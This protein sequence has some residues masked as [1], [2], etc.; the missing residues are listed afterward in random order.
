LNIRYQLAKGIGSIALSPFTFLRGSTVAE[1]VYK[2]GLEMLLESSSPYAHDATEQSSRPLPEFYRPAEAFLTRFERVAATVADV[3][4]RNL[5]DIGCAEGYMI[6]RVA[7]ECGVFALGLEMDRR[8]IRV[9]NATSELDG[10]HDYGIVPARVGPELLRRLPK[11]DVVVCFSVLHHVIRGGG[12]EAG[13]EFLEAIRTITGRRFVFDMDSPKETA[14]D[15]EWAD[16]LGFFEGEV[17]SRN[18]E[19]LQSAGFVNVTHVGDTPGYVQSAVR[20]V[21]ICSVPGSE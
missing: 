4:A 18:K 3:N 20:P 21:F 6:S 7:K 16:V 5:L 12:M 9:G 2:R 17:T 13:T 14:N 8:R 11:F 1:M 10:D 19:F 15:P